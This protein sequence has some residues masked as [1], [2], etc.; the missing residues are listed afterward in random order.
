MLQQFLPGIQ[1]LPTDRALTKEDLLTEPFLIEKDGKLEMYYAPHN[2]YINK[3]AKIIIVGITPG[4]SQMKTA[5]GQFIESNAS[6]ENLEKCLKAVKLAAGF[7][8]TMRRNL[9]HMLDQCDIPQM[10]DISD[11]SC[12]FGDSR[13]FLH[14]T[15]II[16][17]PVFLKGKN[18]TGHQPPIDRS[19]LLQRYAYEE[20]PNE[21][22]QIDP[23]AL[24]IP[25]GKVVEQVI[26]KL[27]EEGMLPG[28]T[29]LNGFPHPSGANGHRVKQFEQNRKQLRGKVRMWG[30]L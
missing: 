16:K 11:S 13:H 18:Y 21:L 19:P 4:W 6:G 28:H 17:Y 3:K 25:L 7:A 24:V 22:T 23:H 12:L 1:T 29:Y 15:S 8:G 5:F 30:E 20:F 9:I 14:T 27:A 2:E 26:F 10:L